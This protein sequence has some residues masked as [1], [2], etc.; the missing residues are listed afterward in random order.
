MISPEQVE[1]DKREEIS[2]KRVISTVAVTMVIVFCS[3]AF[4][5]VPVPGKWCDNVKFCTATGLEMPQYL[6]IEISRVENGKVYGTYFPVSSP[7]PFEA[8]YQKGNGNDVVFRFKSELSGS[9]FECTLSKDGKLTMQRTGRYGDG[10]HWELPR[11]K[12]K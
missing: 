2:M 6:S 3:L 1:K 7:V 12:D 11:C 8:E 10:S 5:E 4:A 9:K